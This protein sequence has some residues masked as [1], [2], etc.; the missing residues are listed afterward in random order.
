[1]INSISSKGQDP[2]KVK[3][4]WMIHKNKVH[5]GSETR[6]STMNARWCQ[7]QVLNS[8]PCNLT[9][10]WWRCKTTFI[11]PSS[12]HNSEQLRALKLQRPTV[13]SRAVAGARQAKCMWILT[14]WTVP[15]AKQ[16][17]FCPALQ[18]SRCVPTIISWGPQVSTVGKVLWWAHCVH[19]KS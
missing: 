17:S 13:I 3:W 18:S 7:A 10:S 5:K 15:S 6:L 9:L 14:P 4:C 19:H 1:M 8:F 16:E 11:N 2:Q 12:T